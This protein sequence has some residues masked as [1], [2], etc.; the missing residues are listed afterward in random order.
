[1]NFYNQSVLK[2]H[3]IFLCMQSLLKNHSIFL[4]MQSLLIFSFDFNL[5]ISVILILEEELVEFW[6]IALCWGN[7]FKNNIYA[8]IE[9]YFVYIYHRILWQILAHPWVNKES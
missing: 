9:F 1:M 2:N 5:T 8:R 7:I 4:C 3:S 6:K